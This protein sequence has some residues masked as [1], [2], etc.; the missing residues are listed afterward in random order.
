MKP[1]D[2]RVA[3]TVDPANSIHDIL[4]VPDIVPVYKYPVRAT[5][6]SGYSKLG[7]VHC[8]GSAICKSPSEDT[9]QI[10]HTKRII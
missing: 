8:T 4:G 10:T 5:G 9:F 7:F 2:N 3:E 6:V 1:I